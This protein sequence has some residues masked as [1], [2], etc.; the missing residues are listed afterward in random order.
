[1][2]ILVD[3]HCDS[4]KVAFDKNISIYDSSLAFNVEVALKNL[5]YM[6][7][8]ASFIHT[9]Y[10]TG[11]VAFKRVNDLLDKFY[12]EYENNRDRKSVV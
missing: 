1:M 9:K 7:L 2:N 3:G 12:L 6:Q 4:L 11:N 10:D 8:L 5:P